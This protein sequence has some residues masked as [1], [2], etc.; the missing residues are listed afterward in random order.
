MNEDKHQ[1]SRGGSF[2]GTLA[3][4]ILR[5]WLAARAIVTGIEKFAGFKIK[6]EEMVDA[7]T[8][9]SMGLMVD[10]K[11]KFYSMTNYAAI[12]DSLKSQFEREPLMPA[13]MTTPFYAVL[14]WALILLGVMLLAGIG[15]RI[16]LFL[17]G[18]LY[19]GLTIGLILI[20][21]DEGVAWLGIH[22][23]LVALALT[24]AKHNRFSLLKKW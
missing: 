1:D 3:F 23:G 24:L 20:K 8:G 22:V 21:Q 14:G 2:D 12:P 18:L 17:Q 16:S 13:A 6:N 11:Y 5:F 7:A 9:E 10:V 19:T 4:L 15:T